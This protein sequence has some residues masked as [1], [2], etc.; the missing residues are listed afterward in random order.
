[1][2]VQDITDQP[3]PAAEQPGW[4]GASLQREQKTLK[5]IEDALQAV[6]DECKKDKFWAGACKH[7]MVLPLRD[8]W[9]AR[10]PLRTRAR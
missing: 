6:A 4:G 9:C 1:M 5:T 2:S 3:S 10:L 7:A 8:P